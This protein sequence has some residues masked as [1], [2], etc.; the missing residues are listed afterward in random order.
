MKRILFL[1]F[2]V[3]FTTV[4]DWPQWRG[5]NRNGVVVDGVPLLG[6][7]PKEGL[8]RLW[9]SEFIPSNDDG[10]H[11]SVVV[12]GQ[13]VYLALV[14]HTD[15]PTK[16]R[17]I[18]DLVLRKLG[19]RGVT[20][21]GDKLVAK[22]EKDRVGLSPRLRGAKLTE[23]IDKWVAENF[24]K[25]QQQVL[26][27]W[28]ASR[29]KKGKSAIPVKDLQKLATMR[30]HRFEDDAAFK[31]WLGEQGFSDAVKAQ[32]VKAVPV[33]RKVAQDVVV[34]LDAITGKTLWK[35]EAPGEPTGRRSS[36]TP[37]VANG[38][39]Y[40]MGARQAYC[41]DAVTGKPVWSA[42]IPGKNVASSFLVAEG[43]AFVMAG[44]LV[45]L[46]AKTGR[47][48]WESKDARGGNSSPVHWEDDGK[49]FLI[50]NA[51]REVI[52]LNPAD[53]KLVWQVKGGGDST[54]V[55]AGNRMTVYS[56]DKKIGLAGY[57]IS[58]IGAKM[59]WNI[60][61]EARRTQSTPVIYQGHVY[62]VGGDTQMCVEMETGKVKWKEK[63]QS[64]ISSPFIA[65][66]RLFTFEKKGSELVMLRADPL[67]H[68]E[69]GKARVRAMWCPSPVLSRGKLVLRMDNGVA[70]FDL[71]KER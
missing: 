1:T 54:P 18:N 42:V 29:F 14:W 48:V 22:M 61:L 33:T 47:V 23:W 39:V 50:I 57:S 44:R 36:S 32:V 30:E 8:K 19:N 51:G 17:A 37:C 15:V 41:V 7:F 34:C 70:C 31:K 13:R 52:C 6:A 27:S 10:G 28:V 69:I 67:A 38:R 58:A 55:V 35:A 26:A 56:S 9:V 12:A 71:A 65:D 68:Y 21:L 62:H 60:P 59:L 24:N 11:G 49:T 2:F 64:N 20:I 45:A 25:E 3:A 53:G 63:R 66:G 46:D 5:P 43:K 16:T 40:A 4:A